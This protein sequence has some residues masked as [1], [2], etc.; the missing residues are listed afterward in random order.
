LVIRDGE[1]LQQAEV[2]RVSETQPSE[3]PAVEPLDG[4][5]LLWLHVRDFAA[6]AMRHPDSKVQV[7]IGNDTVQH[8]GIVRVSRH[9]FLRAID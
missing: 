5:V 9:R 8:A 3:L 2:A 6:P 7:S 1:A 4:V